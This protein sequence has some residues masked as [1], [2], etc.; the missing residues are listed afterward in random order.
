MDLSGARFSGACRLSAPTAVD[1]ALSLCERAVCWQGRWH[2]PAHCTGR[3]LRAQNPVSGQVGSVEQPKFQGTAVARPFV[4]HIPIVPSAGRSL[5]TPPVLS[6]Q[7]P[8]WAREGLLSEQIAAWLFRGLKLIKELFL[9][10]I[11]LYLPAIYML[12]QALPPRMRKV[13]APGTSSCRKT[14]GNEMSTRL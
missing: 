6:W 11:S 1:S 9:A 8:P 3:D 5:Q 4:G 7:D 12:M 2:L 13:S 10:F 14:V